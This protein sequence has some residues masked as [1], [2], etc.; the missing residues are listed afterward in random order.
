MVQNKCDGGLLLGDE[1]GSRQGDIADPG[2][3]K[4]AWK[5]GAHAVMFL[6]LGFVPCACLLVGMPMHTTL[7]HSASLDAV[8]V[9]VAPM[10][11]DTL[12]NKSVP[13]M[14]NPSMWPSLFC[15]ALMQPHGPEVKLMKSQFA[16]RAGIFGCNDQVVFCHG[17]NVTLGALDNGVF[18]TLHIPKVAMK[19]GNVAIP[20]QMTNSWLNVELFTK[21]FDAMLHDGRFWMYDWVVKV[22][23]DAVFF[24]DRLRKHVEPLTSHKG[25]GTV[26][27]RNCGVNPWIHLMGAIE[28]FSKPAMQKYF[29]EK[30]KCESQLS[31]GGWGEDYY[32]EHCMN[33]L[34]IEYVNDYKLLGQAGCEFAPCTDSWRA[35]FHPFKDPD[36]WWQCWERSAGK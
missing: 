25:P 10:V 34:G 14:K 17:G 15:F 8:V 22:D 33:H 2:Q 12:P 18:K 29:D 5:H 32:M 36:S 20:G 16:R 30:W 21:V 13:T 4:S 27:I 24:P 23:P 35:A 11:N 1:G 9:K 26:Y 6:M 28:V 19:K 3:R 7:P 31:W